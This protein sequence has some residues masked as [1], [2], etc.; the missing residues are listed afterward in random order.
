MSEKVIMNKILVAVSSLP[1]SLV[2]RA[3][4]GMGYVGRK[5]FLPVGSTIT[6]EPNM[7]V[8]AD[9]RPI[10]FGVPG[11]GDIEGA[12]DGFPVSLEVKTLTGQQRQYQKNYQAAWEKAGGIY[13][14]AR[15]PEEALEKLNHHIS[16]KS[17]DTL[18]GTK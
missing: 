16:R 7:V 1:R 12:V 17:L 3:N 18:S 13:I 14:V 2:K 4:A 5:L 10:K 11:Q 8:L 6:I 9:A 15:S